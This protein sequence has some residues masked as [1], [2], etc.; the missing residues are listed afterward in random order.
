[1]YL[2]LQWDANAAQKYAL[3]ILFVLKE[4]KIWNEPF[5]YEARERNWNI[6][7]EIFCCRVIKCLPDFQVGIKNNQ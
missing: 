7:T 6:T 1:M 2:Y 4:D 5:W 3:D